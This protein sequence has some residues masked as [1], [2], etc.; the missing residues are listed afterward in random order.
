MKIGSKRYS[1][2]Y[3]GLTLLAIIAAFMT[4][5]TA[6]VEADKKAGAPAAAAAGKS[7]TMEN[8]LAAYDG[9]SN[10]RARYIAFARKADDEGYAKAASLFRAAARA[11]EIHANNHAAVINDLGGV[12]KADVKTPDAKSTAENLD[13]AVKGESYER[14]TMYPG[15]LKQAREDNLKEAVR[16]FN[17]AM[18]AEAEH[19][20]LYSEAR[21]EL[22]SWKSAS[23]GF[24]VCPV[25]GFTTAELTFAKCPSCFTSREKF[26]LVS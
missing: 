9:E 20:K 5:C 6:N 18:A 4:G 12:P 22:A 16:T 2:R 19:A 13:A 1:G 25:C 11:E 17:L 7:K 3:L 21:A 23:T 14:D 10:A 24:Y 26:E 8:L 15:F